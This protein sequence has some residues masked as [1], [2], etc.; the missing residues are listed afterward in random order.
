ML[1]DIILYLTVFLVLVLPVGNA[2][3]YIAFPEDDLP[4]EHD[5]SL[6]KALFEPFKLIL[7]GDKWIV[8]KVYLQ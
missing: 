8:Y 1:A 7:L 5:E 2:I 3:C 4:D 6:F